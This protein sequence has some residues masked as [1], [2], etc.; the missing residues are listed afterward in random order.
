VDSRHDR[1]RVRPWREI[2]GAQEARPWREMGGTQEVD[3]W[4]EMDRWQDGDPWQES[5]ERSR[6]RRGKSTIQVER[7]RPRRR[8][9][10]R[11]R[12][13]ILSARTIAVLA[14]VAAVLVTVLAHNGPDESPPPARAAAA[15]G[16]TAA[17]HA[18]RRS[19]PAGWRDCPLAVAPGGYVNPLEAAIVSPERI[20]QGVDYA[21]VGKLVAIG[22]GRI[23][24]LAANNSG[25]P[26]AFIEYQLL[27]GADAGCYVYYAEGVTPADGLHVGDTVSAGQ[28]IAT[29]IPVYPTGIEIGWG[30]G[31]AT[32]AYARVA[33]QWIG[34]DD[35]DNIASAAGKN[36]SA[37]IAALG[38]PPGK[39]EG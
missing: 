28:P 21:G 32:K 22:A 7:N 2:D 12:T 9:A 25:W 27:D 35:E 33:G 30:A 3:S 10:T 4:Q 5:L 18:K 6:A 36:F 38:G 13:R 37:L 8:T 24:H 17:P 26:G 11:L 31:T 19:R 14:V 34:T 15:H 23:T 39:D 20:D 1:A 16:T 29:I